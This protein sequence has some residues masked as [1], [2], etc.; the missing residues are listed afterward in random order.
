M[1]RAAN[2]VILLAL[3]AGRRCSPPPGRAE[4]RS[5]AG[6]RRGRI[7]GRGAGAIAQTFNQAAEP[8]SGRGRVPGG[9]FDDLVEAAY[10]APGTGCWRSGARPGRRRSAGAARVPDHLRRAGARAGRGGA[11]Q[12][13]RS[14]RGV[15]E[16]SFEDGSRRGREVRPGVRGDGLALDRPRAAVSAGVAVLRPGGHLAFWD[17]TH[18][19]PDGGDPFFDEIQEVYEEIGEGLPPGAVRQVP[20]QLTDYSADI[21]ASG[22]FSVVCAASSTGSGSTTRRGTSSC[23]ARS[24]VTSRWRRGSAS[25][26]TARSG[27]AWPGARPAP[28]AATGARPSTWPAVSERYAIWPGFRS[29]TME[30]GPTVT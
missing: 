3:E 8:T 15:I 20:G 18:V 30:R 16:A 9:L 19:L 28:C 12:P 24:P 6:G 23:S 1:A 29:T 4:N 11:A 17:G 13:G 22:L 2:P 10:L 5:A 7:G 21:E 14:R 27:G 26:C 25:G